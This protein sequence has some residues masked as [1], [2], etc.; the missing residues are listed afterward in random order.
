[1]ILLNLIHPISL[2]AC[3]DFTFD[4]NQTSSRFEDMD[5]LVEH[6]NSKHKNA[7]PSA[8]D[9]G[10]T[11]EGEG[12]GG[13]DKEKEEDAKGGDEKPQGENHVNGAANGVSRSALSRLSFYLS[14]SALH[15]TFSYLA[16]LSRF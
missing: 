2:Y 10:G 11:G 5:E 7:S 1:M 4:F 16:L 9:E 13:G 6:I 12:G 3:I 15:T 14:L 8:N